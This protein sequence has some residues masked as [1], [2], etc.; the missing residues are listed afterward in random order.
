MSEED[1][2]LRRSA[3]VTTAFIGLGANEG[4][5]LAQMRAAVQQLDAHAAVRVAAVS[6]V[7][8]TEAHTIEPEDT[9]PAFLNA[10]VQV[11]TELSP[12]AL[13]AL[14]QH[15]ERIAGR[16]R[17]ANAPRWGPRPIDLDVLTY[18]DDTRDTPALTLPHPR[19]AERRFV[20]R[21]WADLAPNLYVPSPFD[22][23]VQQLLARCP[24]TA[25]VRRTSYELAPPPS[26]T[27]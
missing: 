2:S 11:E 27:T 15:L 17:S 24:D 21:P 7:Y 16:D 13:L 4:D 1:T 22:A 23:S 5:R 14:C 26:A 19:L 20:L 18:G 8:E 25:S 9:Q 3:G 10:V 6:P 12:E